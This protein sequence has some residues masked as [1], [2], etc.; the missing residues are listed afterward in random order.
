MSLTSNSNTHHGLLR[1]SIAGVLLLVATAA[2]ADSQAQSQELHFLRAELPAAAEIAPQI[3]QNST[4]QLGARL[5]PLLELVRSQNPDIIAKGLEAEAAIATIEIAGALDDPEFSV[6]FED[7]DT[8]NSSPLPTRLGSVF[9]E[10]E[11][12]FPL[13][14]KRRLRRDVARA[15]AT[16]AKQEQRTVRA[17]IEARIKTAFAEYLLAFEAME[18]TREIRVIVDGIAE[19]AALRYAQGLGSQDDAISAQIEQTMLASELV[20]F[21]RDVKTAR[22][23]I[24]ALLNRPVG[25]PLTAPTE[26]RAMPSAATLRLDELVAAAEARNPQLASIDA[27]IL[28]ERGNVELVD[29]S[30]YPDLTVG[31]TVVDRDRDLSGYEARIG[32]NIPLQWGLRDAQKR[33]AMARV[34]A[35]EA[36]LRASFAEIRSELERAYWG[37]DATQQVVTNLRDRLL[38]QSDLALAAAQAAYQVGQQDL[39]GVLAA[40]RRLR[41]ARLEHLRARLEQQLLLAEIERLIGGDL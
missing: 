9:Y 19:L 21:D 5:E 41:Q 1:A 27:E 39:S 17:D 28:A 33:Q 26:L 8:R 7:V 25:S 24:N 12:K 34:G 35:A 37:L 13:W 11:Q 14:G 3:A 20:N 36:R 23:R 2:S 10:I 30:W 31:F 16:R 40:E 32:F 22:A 6:S 18:A 29:R 38:P 4:G 15:D